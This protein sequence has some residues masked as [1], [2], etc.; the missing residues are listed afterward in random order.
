M[1]TGS[2]AMRPSPRR[3]RWL[4]GA[5]TVVVAV[6]AA[7]VVLGL[8]GGGRGTDSTPEAQAAPTSRAPASVH[9]APAPPTPS[10]SGHTSDANTLPSSLPAVGIGRS[11]SVGDGVTG[12]V[13]ALEAID[14]TGHGRG[15]LAGPAV[16][17]TIRLTNGRKAPVSVDAVATAMTY[18]SDHRPAPPL[19]DPSSKPFRGLLQPGSSTTG[20]YVFTVPADQ[21]SAITVAVG[22]RAGAPFMVF[23]GSAR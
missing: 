18:G 19:D 13:V 2:P 15:D 20:V 6:V 5:A 23:S 22:Y 14:G 16:R 7:L 3:R 12:T 8:T 10:A 4:I 21:R 9:L 1:K 17:A 11:A